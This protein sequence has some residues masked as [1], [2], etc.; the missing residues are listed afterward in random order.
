MNKETWKMTESELVES[1]HV[2]R[3][4]IEN[5]VKKI[6]TYWYDGKAERQSKNILKQIIQLQLR[7]SK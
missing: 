5:L 2:F 1:C 4:E 3:K 7:R 6:N